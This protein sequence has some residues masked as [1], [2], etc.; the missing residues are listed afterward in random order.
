MGEEIP[1]SQVRLEEPRTVDYQDSRQCRNGP[2]GF[3]IY[4]DGRG[5]WGGDAAH[6]YTGGYGQ[7]T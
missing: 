1:L 7:Q 4:C 2:R 5:N 3:R 6:Y